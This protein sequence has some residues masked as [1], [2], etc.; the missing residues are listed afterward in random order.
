MSNALVSIHRPKFI[1]APLMFGI[2]YV[3]GVLVFIFLWTG[4]QYV[5]GFAGFEQYGLVYAT[6]CLMGAISNFAIVLG[7]RWGI[8]GQIGV[9]IIN[10]VAN[11][12]LLNRGIGPGFGLALLLVGL[13]IFDV[14]RNRQLLRNPYTS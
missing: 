8:I 9:W 4:Q 1:L 5:P 7:Y 13:W 11:M 14:Y 2:I 3:I 12:V 6:I 10:A